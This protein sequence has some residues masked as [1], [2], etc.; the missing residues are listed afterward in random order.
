M[1]FR[2]DVT[3]CLRASRC[4]GHLN[5]SH[6]RV[7]KVN[8]RDPFC[9]A[10]SAFSVLRNGAKSFVNDLQ[11]YSVNIALSIFSHG[12]GNATD[13]FLRTVAVLF[14]KNKSFNIPHL[15]VPVKIFRA[16]NGKPTA[17]RLPS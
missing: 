14:S 13:F 10:L 15:C 6:A 1:P 8:R 9:P 4:E 2:K 11:R 16:S 5:E 7:S 3:R 12:S 17:N